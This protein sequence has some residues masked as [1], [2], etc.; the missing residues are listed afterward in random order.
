M[1]QNKTLKRLI[2]MNLVKEI[3]NKIFNILVRGFYW[4]LLIILTIEDKIREWIG[5][6][7]D[8]KD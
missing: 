2:S 1:F 4:I 7:K 3:I 8:N 5:Y 6:N